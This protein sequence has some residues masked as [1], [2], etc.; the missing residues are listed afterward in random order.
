MASLGRQRKS[1]SLTK[2]AAGLVFLA[3]VWAFAAVLPAGAGTTERIVV[4]PQ[5]G[6]AIDGFD[7]VAYF[8][9]GGAWPGSADYECDWGGVTW[10]FRN[11]GNRAAFLAAP[12]VYA[13]QYGGYDPTGVARGVASPGNPEVWLVVGQRLYLF[14]NTQGR[15]SFLADPAGTVAAADQNWP[16]VLR[17]LVP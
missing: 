17:I 14:Y 2:G 13:P 11:M 15:Q 1:R 7:P 16:K 10:R 8:T 4:N 5:N 9:D 6:I 12:Q 3:L